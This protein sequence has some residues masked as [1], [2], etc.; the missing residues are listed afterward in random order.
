[1]KTAFAHLASCSVEL[2][3]RKEPPF[4]RTT[5][6]GGLEKVGKW[7]V[8]G[9]AASEIFDEPSVGLE[10]L[11]GKRAVTVVRRGSHVAE[12]LISSPVEEHAGFPVENE[13]RQQ[14]SFGCLCSQENILSLR[15]HSKD[16]S[17]ISKGFTSYDLDAKEKAYKA[18]VFRNDFPEALVETE[19]FEGD[20]LIF[21]AT[22]Q[23]GRQID[24]DRPCN[25][26]VTT[27]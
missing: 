7:T 5:C 14:I 9:D 24:S 4:Y 17:A 6:A 10:G 15:F 3:I 20:T 18:N 25:K 16:P 13:T 22:F 26:I 21:R 12:P 1:M 19:Q 11:L 2:S 27:A 8:G 23:H